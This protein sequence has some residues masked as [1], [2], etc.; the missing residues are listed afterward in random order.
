VLLVDDEPQ[1]RARLR[2]VLTDYGIVVVAE[3]GSGLEGVELAGRLRPDVVL[4]DLRMPE[5]DGITATRLLAEDLPGC[6]V[7][8]FSAYDDPALTSE[9]HEAGAYSYLVKGCSA[10]TIV[11]VVEKAAAERGWHG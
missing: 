7:I 1:F 9:A 2:E 10:R 4:M 3:A 5:M 8:I 6:P 11:D